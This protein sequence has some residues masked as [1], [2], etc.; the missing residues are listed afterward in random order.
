LLAFFILSCNSFWL[1]LPSLSITPIYLTFS[2][3]SN[4]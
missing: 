4:L 2:T 1:L 3:L